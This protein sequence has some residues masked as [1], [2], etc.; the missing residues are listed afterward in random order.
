M[1]NTKIE[2]C[3]KSWNPVIGCTK[4]SPGCQNCYAERMAC[5]IASIE[6]SK[7]PFKPVYSRVVINGKW[8]ENVIC[9]ET[10]LDEP[11]HWRKP[12]KIF[13]CSMSDLFHEKVPFE[14][15]RSVYGKMPMTK[16]IYQVLTKRP[17][18]AKEFY[19]SELKE[20]GIEWS[21]LP[22]LWLGVSISTQKEAAEKIPILLRIPAAVRFISF[23]PLLEEIYIPGP[24]LNHGFGYAFNQK[25][26]K[27]NW[28]IVG[29][30]SSSK[31]RECKLEWIQDI[32]RHC[33]IAEIPVFVKQILINGRVSHKMSDW[34]KWS[35]IRDWPNWKTTG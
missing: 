34:P 22:N 33:S 8:G 18:R 4:C 30:E 15:I 29:C 7:K 16:H 20:S 27:I 10:K 26:E 25:P 24:L 12:C 2:W 35:R 32:V 23:E 6:E 14:F 9:R 21:T 28:V 3:D 31:R 13:V 19:E 11:L 17:Q 1:A 5:R